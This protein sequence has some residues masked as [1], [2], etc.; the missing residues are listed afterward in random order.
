MAFEERSIRTGEDGKTIW[1]ITETT[2]DAVGHPNKT[3]RTEELP[4]PR[5]RTKQNKKK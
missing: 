4:D 5:N 2:Y 3:I 1:E